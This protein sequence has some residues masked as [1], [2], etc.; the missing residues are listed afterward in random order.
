MNREE[1]SEIGYIISLTLLIFTFLSVPYFSSLLDKR[2]ALIFIL[3]VS[4]HIVLFN[5]GYTFKLTK[6]SNYY[7]Q[8]MEGTSKITLIIVFFSYLY[9]FLHVILRAVSSTDTLL[10]LIV[11]LLIVIGLMSLIG[12]K[13][14]MPALLLR[15]IEIVVVPKKVYIYSKYDDSEPIFIKIENRSK[16]T[17]KFNINIYF[18]ENVMYKIDYDG[19]E[20]TNKFAKE[21]TV[22][23]GNV[24]MRHI[25]MKYEGEHKK[26]NLVTFNIT[27]VN[28][29]YVE[30]IEAILTG[31]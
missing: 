23:G 21:I 13:I 25:Q 10:S 30:N 17:L 14:I 6:F 29:T 28:N 7:L 18:P 16:K 11:P 8:K 2:V 31:Q 1:K 22:E 4:F 27:Y 12:S 15:K 24:W 5:M 3:L 20:G 9:I 26:A 19:I